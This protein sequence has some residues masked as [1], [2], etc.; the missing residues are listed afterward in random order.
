MRERVNIRTLAVGDRF[1]FDLPDPSRPSQGYH[2][3]DTTPC[4]IVALAPDP[5]DYAD[6]APGGWD[7]F[8]PH[9]TR[10]DKP[11]WERAYRCAMVYR[12]E[13]TQ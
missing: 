2:A 5:S 12:I 6:T 7:R 13:V 10:G 11:F 3:P 4:T 1:T 9:Y 8:G